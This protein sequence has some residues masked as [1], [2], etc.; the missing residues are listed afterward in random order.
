VQDGEHWMKVNE[1]LYR[2]EATNF[3][4]G[5]VTIDD[6]IV[7]TAGILKKF[8]GQPISNLYNWAIKNGMKFEEIKNG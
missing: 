7:R 3:V 5:V 6:E 1:V 8:K 4:A 2:I